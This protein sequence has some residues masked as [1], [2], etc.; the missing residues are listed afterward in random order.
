MACFRKSIKTK[1]ITG[2]REFFECLGNNIFAAGNKENKYRFLL[3]D[4]NSTCISEMQ[5]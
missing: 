2:I 3:Y 1:L 4:N 5:I